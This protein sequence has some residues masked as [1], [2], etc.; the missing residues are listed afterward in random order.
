MAKTTAD[1]SASSKSSLM[2]QLYSEVAALS[3]YVICLLAVKLTMDLVTCM[4]VM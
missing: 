3:R 1:G 2:E 4:Y